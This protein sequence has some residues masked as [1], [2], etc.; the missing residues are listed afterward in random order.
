MV[1]ML[2]LGAVRAYLAPEE[3]DMHMYK[4]G[5][6]AAVPDLQLEPDLAGRHRNPTTH[7]PRGLLPCTCGW[8]ERATYEVQS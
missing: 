3:R 5:Q 1:A 2:W 7:L 4:L 8:L 6:V